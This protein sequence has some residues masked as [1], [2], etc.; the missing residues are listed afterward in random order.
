MKQF[1][2]AVVILSIVVGGFAL[3]VEAVSCPEPVR[4][5]R[6]VVES[7]D[8][9]WIIAQESDMWNKMDGQ[10]III[11]M[12]EESNCTAMIY[13]GQVVYIPMYND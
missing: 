1:L 2:M 7:G 13:P 6:Y 9:L 8:T 4:Y 11:D 12:K 3:M 10:Q 5:E